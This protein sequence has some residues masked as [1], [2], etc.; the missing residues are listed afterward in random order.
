MS[1]IRLMPLVAVLLAFACVSLSTAW[2]A[3]AGN[4]IQIVKRSSYRG[5]VVLVRGGFNVFSE[6]FDIIAKKLK[7]RGIK[8]KIYS[9]SQ[10]QQIAS[11][12]ISN[13]KKFGK[14][15]IILIGHSWGANAVIRVA[16]MLQRKGLKVRYMATFAATNPGIAPSN[17]QKLT[18]YYFKK[19]GWG[20]PVRT[21]KSFRGRL[22]NVDMSSAQDANHF[23][24]DEIPKLQSQVINNVLRY[25]RPRRN[26]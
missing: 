19:D 15:P 6:G 22:K 13:Q 26:S 23:N 2:T 21:T 7:K 9:H 10:A 14:K 17:I 20:E 12:I 8:V 24:V 3:N 16:K 18:N 11:S 4:T 1:K 5:D 25:I